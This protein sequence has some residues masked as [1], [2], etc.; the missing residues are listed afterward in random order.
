[1]V[2]LNQSRKLRLLHGSREDLQGNQRAALYRWRNNVCTWT[3]YKQ[4]L[5]FISCE[6]CHEL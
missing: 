2:P 6:R 4:L 3:Y 5:H 1:V